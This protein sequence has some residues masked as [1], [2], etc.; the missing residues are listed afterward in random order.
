MKKNITIIIIIAILIV[1]GIWF[2]LNQKEKMV[3]SNFEECAALGNPILETYP[4]QCQHNNEIFIE[5]IEPIISKEEAINIAQQSSECLEIGTLTNEVNYNSNTK[6]W[7]IDIEVKA[8]SEKEGCNPACVVNE[9]TKTSEIN[10]RCTG[11]IPEE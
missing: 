2:C 7:W 10:W 6:T 9:E 11:L 3:V 4:R 8:E 1:L 5:E